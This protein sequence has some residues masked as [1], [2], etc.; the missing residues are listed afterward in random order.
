MKLGILSDVHGNIRALKAAI[1]Y[2][3]S[4]GVDRYCFLGD[5]L[6]ELPGVQEVCNLINDLSQ[7]KKC[8]IIKGN[9]EEYLLNGICEGHP[10]W[11]E[12][13]SV[14]GML[15]YSAN[16]IN[17]ETKER[18]CNLPISMEVKI[19]DYPAIIICH[20]S[21]KSAKNPVLSHKY[22]LDKELL[23][24]INYKYI[25]HGHTHYQE[26][27]EYEGKHIFNPG[28]IGLPCN[29][30]TETEFM[31]LHGINNEWVPE[32]INLEYDYMAVVNDMHEYK[33]YEIAPYWAKATETLITGINPVNNGRMLTK[34]MEL[35]TQEEGKCEWPLISEK[36]MKEAFELLSKQYYEI[37]EG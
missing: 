17:N 27:M 14:V 11:D 24:T 25:I 19:D 28:T 4:S 22:G 34:A 2:M 21:P 10:E 29:K 26:E 20:G 16:S 5:Y 18:L 30:R 6:G 13:K 15:R 9:K 36:Y 1:D 33:L 32:F 3:E 12:Y 8:Y 23:S 35:C 7:R 31:I 37:K